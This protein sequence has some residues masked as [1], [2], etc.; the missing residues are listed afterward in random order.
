MYKQILNL[1]LLLI[2]SFAAKASTVTTDLS[3]DST[4][5][6]S[7]SSSSWFSIDLNLDGI[8]DYN[9]SWSGGRFGTSLYCYGPSG[10]ELAVLSS[11]STTLS[12]IDSNTLISSSHAWASAAGIGCTVTPD[13]TDAGDKFIG[14]KF[15]A[16]TSAYYGWIHISFTSSQILTIM[17]YAYENVSG[18]SIYTPSSSTALRP[19]ADF[20]TTTTTTAMATTMIFTDISSNSPLSWTWTFTPATV[21]FMGGTTA[22]SQNPQVQFGSAGKYTVK[23]KCSNTAGSDSITKTDYMTVIGKPAAAFS[24]GTVTTDTKTTVPFTDM[25][26]NTPTAWLWTFTP[27]T[28]TFMGGTSAS[29]QNPQVQ[30]NATGKYTVK[31]KASNTS[32]SDSTTK[33]NYI[34]VV[35]PT[36]IKLYGPGDE[37]SIFP[38]PA[39]T[40]VTIENPGEGILDILDISGK[41]QWSAPVQHTTMQLDISSL[42]KG[43]YTLRV[44]NGQGVV[45][46]KLIV[47]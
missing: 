17:S 47:Q 43:H 9:F 16:G 8:E 25:S 34:T 37:F 42:P 1:F 40:S 6:L 20:T 35:P 19:G 32:G 3:P 12:V 46:R 23:L 31:L 5:T 7:G 36:G 15:M 30:F 4:K 14:V 41:V 10:N 2:L 24:A 29:S 45:N 28:V 11:G 27:A 39:H 13:F 21:T 26:T 38:N 22:T 18:K 33:I 44:S